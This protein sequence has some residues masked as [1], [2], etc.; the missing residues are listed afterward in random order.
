MWYVNE[1]TGEGVRDRIRNHKIRICLGIT[2][3][4]KKNYGA[5]VMH[6]GRVG[7]VGKSYTN[8]AW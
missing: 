3:V 6:F 1:N 2:P 5:K 8:L 4:R 7:I